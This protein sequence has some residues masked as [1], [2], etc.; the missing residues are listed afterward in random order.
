MCTG[1][2]EWEE[3]VIFSAGLSHYQEAT[4]AQRIVYDTVFVN[5]GSG[6]NNIT[7]IFTCP[8][9]RDISVLLSLSHSTFSSLHSFLSS[10]Y[11]STGH[12]LKGKINIQIKLMDVSLK[13][14]VV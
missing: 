12:S 7:G 6:Y 2:K 9:V 3:S 11:V 5:E 10:Q 4:K 13:T 8:R 14:S 1:K